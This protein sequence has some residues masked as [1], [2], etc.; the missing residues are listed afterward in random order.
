M[1]A[2]TT[3]WELL[4]SQI[5]LDANFAPDTVRVPRWGGQI[6]TRKTDSQRHPANFGRFSCFLEDNQSHQKASKVLKYQSLTA[7]TSMSFVEFEPWKCTT[8]WLLEPYLG[9]CYDGAFRMANFWIN[10]PYKKQQ[11]KQQ[12]FLGFRATGGLESFDGF[13][14]QNES[15]GMQKSNDTNISSI[16]GGRERF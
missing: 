10:F 4:L 13:I 3:Q 11:Q 5:S 15:P 6:H 1:K 16:W 9:A 12:L 8:S 2:I 7:F 14:W